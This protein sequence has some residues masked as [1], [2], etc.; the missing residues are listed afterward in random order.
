M[1]DLRRSFN[2]TVVQACAQTSDSDDNEIEDFY[3]QLQ[4][5]TDQTSKKDI[6]VVQGH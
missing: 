6:L 4:N 2:I 1:N 5:V 3:D